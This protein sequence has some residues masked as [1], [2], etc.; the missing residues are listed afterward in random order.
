MRVIGRAAPRAFRIAVTLVV[1]LTGL[2]A[3]PR[4]GAAGEGTDMLGD[5]KSVV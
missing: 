4:A 2:A 1:T 3:G 5:R